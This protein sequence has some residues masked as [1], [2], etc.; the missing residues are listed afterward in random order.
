MP[1]RQISRD[2]YIPTLLDPLK[3]L[4]THMAAFP[5]E[6]HK[7]LSCTVIGFV[8]AVDE[9]NCQHLL[10]PGPAPAPGAAPKKLWE[11]AAV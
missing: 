4:Y 9:L 10:H 8:P 1:P 6:G 2:M 7:L 5:L 11:I 3:P